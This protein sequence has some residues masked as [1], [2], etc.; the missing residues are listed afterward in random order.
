MKHHYVLVLL[1]AGIFIV[2]VLGFILSFRKTSAPGPDVG[3]KRDTVE[4]LS[5]VSENPLK[6]VYKN[7]FE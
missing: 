1:L 5:S 7:P 2:G 6:D 3:V 4:T